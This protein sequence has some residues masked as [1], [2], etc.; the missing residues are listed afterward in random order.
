MQSAKGKT[1]VWKLDW[2]VLPGAGRWENPLMGWASSADYMQGTELKFVT[3]EE[4]VAFVSYLDLEHW[5]C[6]Q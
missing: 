6:A 3:A 1:K 4:A 5:F 2:D